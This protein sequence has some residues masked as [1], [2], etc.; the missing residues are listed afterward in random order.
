[1]HS[2]VNNQEP[3]LKDNFFQ[4]QPGLFQ[5]T[6]PTLPGVPAS[7]GAPHGYYY[8]PIANPQN[9]YNFSPFGLYPPP[10]PIYFQSSPTFLQYNY[11]GSNSQTNTKDSFN[12]TNNV[13]SDK[14]NQEEPEDLSKGHATRIRVPHKEKADIQQ[15]NIKETIAVNKFG[16]QRQGLASPSASVRRVPVYSPIIWIW[17][18]RLTSLAH[19]YIVWLQ[20]G[21][22]TYCFS[23]I[24]WQNSFHPWLCER[25]SPGLEVE[26]QKRSAYIYLGS[27]I[28]L[29]INNEI[30][31]QVPIEFC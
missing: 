1:M 21:G 22:P 13:N 25:P 8:D 14:S 20:S 7:P 18:Q 24:D 12:V 4:S 3:N 9:G 6:G 26:H 11:P 27:E 2:S 19:K 10:S 15:T 5:A 29:V 17:L 16:E 23:A 30:A 31:F 28:Q